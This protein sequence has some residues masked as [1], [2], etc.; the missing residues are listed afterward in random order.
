MELDR[1]W[2]DQLNNRVHENV[3]NH[4]K[5]LRTEM[6]IM[7]EKI[8]EKDEK[9]GNRRGSVH[10]ALWVLKDRID[11]LEQIE[12]ELNDSKDSKLSK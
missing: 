1:S 3:K 7:G 8:I 11:E 12:D 10:T 4:I 6:D 5:V 9:T 2:K